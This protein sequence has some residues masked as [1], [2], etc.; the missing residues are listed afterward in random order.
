MNREELV[1]VS[2]LM[3]QIKKIAGFGVSFDINTIENSAMFSFEEDFIKAAKDLEQTITCT[4][5][6]SVSPYPYKWSFKYNGVEFYHIS[7]KEYKDAEISE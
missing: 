6:P 5:R 4:E 2:A 1:V 7:E 3:H